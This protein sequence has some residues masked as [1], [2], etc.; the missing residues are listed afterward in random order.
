MRVLARAMS[1]SKWP[2]VLVAAVMLSAAASARAE[3]VMA[4]PIFFVPLT[5][6]TCDATNIGKKPVTVTIEIVNL[7]GAEVVGSTQSPDAGET[8]VQG[9]VPPS[10]GFYGYCRVS[11]K[12]S[13]NG[14]RVAGEI[15]ATSTTIPG[16]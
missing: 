1:C 8:A 4:T 16:Y 5:G 10:S 15:A 11:G 2:S 13:K 6:A 14:L 12:F 3:T 7:A 9:Y